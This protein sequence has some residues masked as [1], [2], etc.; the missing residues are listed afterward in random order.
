MIIQVPLDPSLLSRSQLKFPLTNGIETSHKSRLKV[1]F[2]MSQTIVLN[3]C[4]ILK[5][6]IW[7]SIFFRH[8]VQHFHN[9][10]QYILHTCITLFHSHIFHVCHLH[11][12]ISHG[13]GPMQIHATWRHACKSKHARSIAFTWVYRNLGKSCISTEARPRLTQYDSI[14][15]C[16]FT[17]I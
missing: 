3:Y 14:V 1:A 11:S 15:Y 7:F 6:L 17:E 2:I 9:S 16:L 5:M 4:T 12:A 13:P 8:P 10:V